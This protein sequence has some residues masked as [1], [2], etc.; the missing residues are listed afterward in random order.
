MDDPG[1]RRGIYDTGEAFDVVGGLFG[2]DPDEPTRPRSRSART[3]NDPNMDPPTTDE[4]ILGVE[5]AFLPEFVVGL[6]Y[7]RRQGSDIADLRELFNQPGWKHRYGGCGAVCR[8][9]SDHLQL[10]G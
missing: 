2:F 9:R 10:P 7:T 6:Q 5:H 4:I 8:C 1:G 3:V